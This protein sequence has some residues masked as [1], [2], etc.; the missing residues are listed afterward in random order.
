MVTGQY[1]DP[2]AGRLTF[3]EYAEAWRASQV[4][5]ATTAAHVETMLRRHV[6]PTL[7]DRPLGAVL[8]SDV[9][10]LLKRLSGALA[11][12]TV[13]VVHRIVAGIFK[14]AVRDRRIASSPCEDTRLPKAQRE[15]V[16]PLGLDVVRRFEAAMPDRYRTLVTLAA[17]TGLRQGEAFGLTVD[18]VNFLRGTLTVNS[19]LS[20]SPAPRLPGASEDRGVRPGDPA[21]PGRRGRLGGSPRGLAVEPPRL[22]FG[23]WPTHPADTVLRAGLAASHMPGRR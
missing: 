23:G 4:H 13:G 10:A 1:V 9:Q 12:S 15:R 5:R 7:G 16:E 8:P 6:Y 17:G 22:H 14:A 20:C 2:R 21:P 11:P 19:N 3:R 18:R